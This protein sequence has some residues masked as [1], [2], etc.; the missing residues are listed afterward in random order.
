M[1]W[2]LRA[3]L[4]CGVAVGAISLTSAI[5]LLRPF[6]L[7]L[8]F[9]LVVL[10]CWFL[11]MTGGVAGAVTDAVLVDTFLTP[12]QLH[13]ST[14]SPVEAVRLTAFLAVSLLLGWTVRKLAQQ[15]A[16]LDN[17]YLQQR[18]IAADA[19]RRLAEERARL[20]E[21]QRDRDTLLRVALRT[22]G[23]GVWVWDLKRGAIQWS[24]E[25]YRMAG[26][27]PQAIEPTLEEWNRFVHPEDVERLIQARQRTCKTGEEYEERY[28]L[29]RPDGSVHWVES[30]G[31]C[32]IDD[33]GRVARVLGVLWDVTGRKQTEEAMLRAEKLAVAG[34]LAATVAHEIN[35]PLEAVSNLLF[36]VSLSDTV[37]A[38]RE[39]AEVAMG[40]V[41]RISAITQ[42]TLKFHRQTGSP[43]SAKLSEIVSMVLALFHARFQAGQI[44]TDLAVKSEQNVACMPSEVQQIFANLVTNAID[45][46]PKGGRLAVRLS[47]SRDWRNDRP[48]GARRGMR[49]TFCD[50]GTGIERAAM[51]HIFEPFY[52]TKTE[53]GTG[54]GLWVVAELAERHKGHVS[55]W[56]WQRPGQSGTAISVFLPFERSAPK[57][58]RADEHG[59]GYSEAALRAEG[60][61]FLTT[62]S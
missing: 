56:S 35:N 62:N 41:M 34:R 61:S 13:F 44:T 45:A 8:A 3:L 16:L 14:Q 58:G 24:D 47:A 22:N 29:V 32:Q 59:A 33:E 50:S 53:T 18:L 52:T 30:L 39:H 28:R 21:E 46:M 15:R 51:R 1:P 12:Q 26:V 36:L 49:V 6:P 55:A 4:G 9:P 42:Q 5:V 40:E 57:A 25:M 11:G 10:T 2:L 7:L 20:S 37:A 60:V 54:L 38:A 31:T 43:Q 23:M 17:H 19:E 27:Q 48:N